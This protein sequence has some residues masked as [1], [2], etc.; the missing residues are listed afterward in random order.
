MRHVEKPE[1]LQLLEAYKRSLPAFDCLLCALS[2]ESLCEARTITS[3]AHGV[4][5]LNRF[6]QRPGH[7]MVVPRCH[8]THVP[9]LPWPT[10]AAL[11]RLAYDANTAVARVLKPVRIY[12]AVFGSTAT[13][14]QS[15]KHLHIHV[16]P[17]YEAND[18]ARP[19]RAF[20]WTEGIFVYEDA[21]A[22]ELTNALRDAWPEA[23]AAPELNVST[24]EG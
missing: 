6:G 3:D 19:S 17:I 5:L 12:N 1:A 22:R 4:V 24:A 8:A 10:Y 7:V 15:F 18:T 2:R 11:Q 14:A 20:T 21:E 9:E 16:L 13:V 23:H